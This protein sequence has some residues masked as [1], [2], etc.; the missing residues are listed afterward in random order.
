VSVIGDA[1]QTA[2]QLGRVE[3]DAA[4]EARDELLVTVAWPFWVTVVLTPRSA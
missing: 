3:N 4:A 2:G 1:E